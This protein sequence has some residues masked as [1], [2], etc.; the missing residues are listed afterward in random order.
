M[1]EPRT[2]DVRTLEFNNPNDQGVLTV[3]LTR[4]DGHCTAIF[5]NAD[6]ALREMADLLDPVGYGREPSV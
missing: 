3:S 5:V 4:D 2:V 1:P 6:Q